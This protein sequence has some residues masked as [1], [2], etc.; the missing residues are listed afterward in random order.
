VSSA[1]V[2]HDLGFGGW[3]CTLCIRGGWNDTVQPTAVVGLKAGRRRRV[4][5]APRL[6]QRARG[7][8]GSVGAR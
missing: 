3:K 6:A 8:T 2:E 7:L 5:S 1:L 4:L